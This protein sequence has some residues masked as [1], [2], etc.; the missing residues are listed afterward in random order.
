[1]LQSN[2]PRRIIAR[3]FIMGGTIAQLPIGQQVSLTGHFDSAVVLKAARPVAKS[4][5]CHVRLPDDPR[6]TAFVAWGAMRLNCWTAEVVRA[7]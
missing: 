1:M 5:E 3:L 4:Y 6:Q 2:P 7:S